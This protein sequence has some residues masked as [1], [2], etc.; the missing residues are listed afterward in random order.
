MVTTTRK[1]TYEDYAKTP[2][3]ERYELLDGELVFMPS[4]K[5][6]HQRILIKLGM[7]IYTFVMEKLLGSV[8]VAPFDVVLSDT[9]TVQPDILFISNERSHIITEPNVQG[10]PDLAVEIISPSDPNRDRVRKRGI[11]ERHGVAEYWLVDPYAGSVTV[12][13]LRDGS[14]RTEGIYGKG[15]TL[16]SPT[17]PGF[18]LDVSDL[19][20]PRA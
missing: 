2:D 3:D 4:P 14:Y 12:L 16:T 6:I 8:Y 1:L 10:A 5:E 20:Q 18:A 13:T 7:L 17:L 15:D 9:N 19:F 11:Y